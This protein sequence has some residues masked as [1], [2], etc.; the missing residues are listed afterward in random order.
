[1]QVLKAQELLQGS[2]FPTTIPELVRWHVQFHQFLL[3]EIL[4]PLGLRVECT[5]PR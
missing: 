5:P 2:I 4:F 1:M 3:L